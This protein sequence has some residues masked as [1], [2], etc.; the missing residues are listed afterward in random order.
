MLLWKQEAA[1][2]KAKTMNSELRHYSSDL[3]YA[4]VQKKNLE[5]LSLLYS[6]KKHFLL[7]IALPQISYFAQS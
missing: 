3:Y 4:L 2:F 7:W 5:H 1:E 6:F